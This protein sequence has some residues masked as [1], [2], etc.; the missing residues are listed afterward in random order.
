MKGTQRYERQAKTRA[1]TVGKPLSATVKCRWPSGLILL[2]AEFK[3][4]QKKCN[5]ACSI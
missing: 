3:S 5:F 2:F 4:I 1:T